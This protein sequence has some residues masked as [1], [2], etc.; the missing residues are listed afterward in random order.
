M[1][2]QLVR[3]VIL[4]MVLMALMV[5][6]A[7]LAP[8]TRAQIEVSGVY[9]HPETWVMQG[10]Q[11]T[12][13]NAMNPGDQPGLMDLN[14]VVCTAW[15]ATA[16]IPVG[17][18]W[19][20][21]RPIAAAT[22][23]FYAVHENGSVASQG[24]AVTDIH[25]MATIRFNDLPVTGS[26]DHANCADTPSGTWE[27]Y[28]FYAYY[29]GLGAA[30]GGGL[31]VFMGF[32]ECLLRG[33]CTSNWQYLLLEDSEVPIDCGGLAG[34]FEEYGGICNGLGTTIY[35]PAGAL[36]LPTMIEIAQPT[37]PPPFGIPAGA[38]MIDWR[39]IST[40][41]ATFAQPA[42]VAFDYSSS[43][44]Y[45]YG[46]LG[47]QIYFFQ[48]GRSQWVPLPTPPDRSALENQIRWEIEQ[49]GFY[50]FIG[51]ID[52]DMDGIENVLET[53]QYNTNPNLPD[54]DLDGGADGN[55]VLVWETMANDPDCD[56]DGHTDGEEVLA[57]TDP[58]D[59]RIYP[60]AID[61]GDHNIGS[62]QTTMTDKG[63]FGYV[64][65]DSPDGIG[66]IYPP[67]G[68]N[69]LYIGGLWAGTDADYVVNRDYASEPPDWE[70]AANPDGHVVIDA[71]PEIAQRIRSSYNDSPHPQAKWLRAYQ[72]TAAWGTAPD[73]AYVLEHIVLAN[74]GSGT[75]ENLYAGQFM[76]FDV[77]P[78]S[79]TA[80]YGTTDLARDLVYM[81]RAAPTP[82]AGLMLIEPETAANVTLILNP[83]YVWP[84]TYVLDADKY[85][86]LAATDAPHIV[87]DAPAANDWSVL[88]SAGP[89]DLDVNESVTLG[90]ALV[91]GGS[92]A[93][94]LT[95][96]DRAR[97]H[98]YEIYGGS[99][100]SE[101]APGA[102]GLRLTAA[103]NPFAGET[104]F[105][106][107]LPV[108]CRAT[109]TVYDVAGRL[110]NV[111]RHDGPTV[112]G[113]QAVRWDARDAQGRRL[114][115]GVYLYRLDA[116]SVSRSGRLVL[117]R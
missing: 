98:Y 49:E 113:E 6:S 26:Q 70:V 43:S 20:P 94:L 32:G 56:G 57:G 36:T 59:P 39:Y 28:T 82:Y 72:E 7:A 81:W 88:V 91:A 31:P 16:D 13:F 55:E 102:G 52:S 27:C 11:F 61:R 76:D 44:L 21:G 15:L 47:T 77:V 42:T 38:A 5:L 90:F 12:H 69:L 107:E 110:V 64:T 103:P 71:T 89:F 14:D 33:E 34:C 85:A 67:G 75:V 30:I 80:N 10:T 62:I 101:S 24:N 74:D 109:L 79:A 23:T 45:G 63:T 9:C 46:R 2:S 73:N 58:N 105:L 60:G 3:F 112:A 108:P 93:E 111:W 86:F 78:A 4:F 8:P 41:G 1:S 68:S 40:G 50:A 97:A 54:S 92:A 35:I 100:V 84:N 22:V 18:G 25:G 66:L 53:S 37:P 99:A 65:A 114:P 51:F 96:A 48:S 104:V 17:A 116:G 83:T 29:A 95:N 106:Y 117:T 19:I 87:H 115:P